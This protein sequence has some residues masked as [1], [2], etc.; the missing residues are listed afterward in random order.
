MAVARVSVTDRDGD[1]SIFTLYWTVATATGVEQWT[2]PHH[3]ALYTIDDDRRAFAAADLA[4][5]FERGGL[6]GRGMFIA[7]RRT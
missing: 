7:Q 5:E 6:L 3:M 4:V 1:I 2:E